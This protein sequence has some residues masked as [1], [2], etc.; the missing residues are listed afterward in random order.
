M[1]K[2]TNEVMDMLK[3]L[4]KDI[5][6]IKIAVKGLQQNKPSSP[7]DMDKK[8][9]S[10]P[11][12]SDTHPF[13]RTSDAG[14]QPFAFGMS[15]PFGQTPKAS[16]PTSTFPTPFGFG[17][18]PLKP[19]S[20]FGFGHKTDEERENGAREKEARGMMEAEDKK[21]REREAHDKEELRKSKLSTEER[22][23][24]EL[25]KQAREQK[26]AEQKAK[27]ALRALRRKEAK[28]IKDAEKLKDAREKATASWQRAEA[29]ATEIE[30][31][32]KLQE[33]TMGFGSI[34]LLFDLRIACS[35]AR[36]YADK[37]KAA[38]DGAN[39]SKS[40]AKALK[41][42]KEAVFA[43]YGAYESKKTMEEQ[44]KRFARFSP[45]QKPRELTKEEL[46]EVEVFNWFKR[47][48]FDET[49]RGISKFI[50][51]EKVQSILSDFNKHKNTKK[52]Y[53]ELSRI[54]HPDTL[55]KQKELSEFEKFKYITLMKVLNAAKA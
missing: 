24:E 19:H 36:R 27:K 53:K 14:K 12:T 4:A 50:D 5:Q 11:P 3:A 45:P 40:V 15:P 54:L 21:S 44:K 52:A 32:L 34:F 8:E 31:Y 25:D 16:K 10:K 37:A 28:A 7:P 9:A 51:N 17:S 48:S 26:E 2:D 30:A 6:D 1:S 42:A 18:V 22:E 43:E 47:K 23:K 38:A 55:N 20:Y 41:F 39:K 46:F 33:S 29:N 49:I 13:G 35:T